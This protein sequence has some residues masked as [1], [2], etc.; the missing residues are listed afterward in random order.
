MTNAHIRLILEGPCH[1]CMQISMRVIK[2][3]GFSL[4]G[5]FRGDDLEDAS[6]PKRLL[7][8]PFMPRVVLLQVKK[9]ISAGYKWGKFGS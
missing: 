4:A 2:Y 3:P 6:I 1:G 5:R 7:R 9:I 8:C